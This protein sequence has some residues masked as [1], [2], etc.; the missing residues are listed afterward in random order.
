MFPKKDYFEEEFVR[1]ILGENDT[2]ET[3]AKLK[4]EKNWQKLKKCKI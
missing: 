2:L 1:N 3:S 4:Q